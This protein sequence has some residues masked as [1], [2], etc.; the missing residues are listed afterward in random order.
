MLFRRQIDCSPGVS[1]TQHTPG[2]SP[3]ASITPPFSLVGRRPRT[4]ELLS[5]FSELKLEP[6]LEP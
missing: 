5:D 2:V 4:A 3:V 1:L 6:F